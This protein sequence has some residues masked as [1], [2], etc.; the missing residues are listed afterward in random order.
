MRTVAPHEGPLASRLAVDASLRFLD[1]PTTLP[2]AIDRLSIEFENR[3]AHLDAE[4]FGRFV[5][6]PES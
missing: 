3:V 4:E 2:L 5:R 6:D 1:T